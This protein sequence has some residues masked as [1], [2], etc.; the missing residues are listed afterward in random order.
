VAWLRQLVADLSLRG[1]GLVSGSVYVGVVLGRVAREVSV[2]LF[3]FPLCRY[4][5]AL[6]YVVV[7]WGRDNVCVGGR[8]RHSRTIDVKKAVSVH[9]VCF[10]TRLT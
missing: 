5:V 9:K 2:E 3:G 8:Q 4:T 6:G 1:P 10:S 7:I